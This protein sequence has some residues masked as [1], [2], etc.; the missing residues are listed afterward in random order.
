MKLD[1][2]F[3]RDRHG[4]LPNERSER[5]ADPQGPLADR[6]VP[7]APIATAD[8]IHRWLDGDLPEPAGMHGDSAR[9]VEFW[10]RIG[11]EAERRRQV[12]TPPHVAAR[13]MASLPDMQVAAPRATPWWKKDLQL[14]PVTALALIGGAF[15]LG[16]L[17]MRFL[18]VG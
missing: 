10:R 5:P 2:N 8:V 15:A 3:E 12:V 4:E 6:E 9:A 16:V 7:L 13:I 18:S 14:S 1:D 17:V 11:E